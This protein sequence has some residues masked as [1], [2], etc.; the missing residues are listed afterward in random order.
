MEKTELLKTTQ[1]I[2]QSQL[3]EAEKQIM[4]LKKQLE[5]ANQQFTSWLIHLACE[6]GEEVEPDVY[7]IEITELG[8]DPLQGCEVVFQIEPNQ[9]EKKLSFYAI[10]SKSEK[11]QK[12]K[13][14]Q[15]QQQASLIVKP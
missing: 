5:I 7:A 1:E 9:E 15:Q 8:A 4:F 10:S 2:L 6:H 11:Y 13:T 14:L 12:L 3:N